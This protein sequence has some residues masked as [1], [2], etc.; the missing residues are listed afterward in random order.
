MRAL[1]NPATVLANVIINLQKL[2]PACVL[3][4][5]PVRLF[6]VSPPSPPNDKPFEACC[7]ERDLNA[8][9]GVRDAVER[10]VY[11]HYDG[12]PLLHAYIIMIMIIVYNM[13]NNI[14]V[15]C[16]QRQNSSDSFHTL[17]LAQRTV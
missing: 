2:S 4:V 10:G 13:C 7:W 6:V 9:G 5:R 11:H 15:S 12:A 16:R 1:E 8:D 14:C 17:A 3:V